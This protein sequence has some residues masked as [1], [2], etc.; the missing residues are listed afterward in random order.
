[1]KSKWSWL[2]FVIPVLLLGISVLIM[3][4]GYWWKLTDKSKEIVTLVREIEELVFEENWEDANSKIT[5]T[6]KV[7]E[8]NIKI[9]QYGVE[10]DRI[11]EIDESLAKIKGAIL[12]KN[13]SN[14]IQDVYVFYR[15][16]DDLG[17]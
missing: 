3:T 9:I 5:E 10:R 7:W 14:A 17:Y 16:W 4:S 8:K 12:T 15:I 1:M 2:Y 13:K 11:F 6:T